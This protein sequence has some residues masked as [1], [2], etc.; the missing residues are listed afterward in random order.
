LL[1]IHK[2]TRQIPQALSLDVQHYDNGSIQHPKR[3]RRMRL[4]K[5]VIERH[6][7]YERNV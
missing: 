1:W 6:R 4:I 2:T 7:P 3:S 5:R